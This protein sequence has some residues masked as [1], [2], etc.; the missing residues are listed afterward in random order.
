[1]DWVQATPKIVNIG[2]LSDDSSDSFHFNNN[3]NHELKREFTMG[4]NDMRSSLMNENE[5]GLRGQNQ[6]EGDNLTFAPMSEAYA[7]KLFLFHFVVETE[8]ACW[9]AMGTTANV[10]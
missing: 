9:M 8:N 2:N 10:E 6:D 4:D 3:P 1:M 5:E 7:I